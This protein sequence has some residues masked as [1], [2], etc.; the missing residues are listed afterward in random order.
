MDHD[1]ICAWSDVR[2]QG[3]RSQESGVRSQDMKD[4]LA[5]PPN[6]DRVQPGQ[7]DLT[8]SRRQESK[9][10]GRNHQPRP[11][12]TL[13]FRGRIT[14]GPCIGRP[15]FAAFPGYRRQDAYMVCVLNWPEVGSGALAKTLGI[16][17]RKQRRSRSQ[18]RV[19]VNPLV[20]HQPLN[21]SRCWD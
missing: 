5:E 21:V 20:G 1:F 15:P 17:G 19:L 18:R 13:R 11:D 9:T 4:G 16:D 7:R 12:Q 14:A 6:P 10:R 3:S 2:S 8:E